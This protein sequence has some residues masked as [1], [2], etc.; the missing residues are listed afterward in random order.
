VAVLSVASMMAVVV[1]AFAGHRI[2]VVA[3]VQSEKMQYS[4]C[5]ASCHG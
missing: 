2:L 1:V 4:Q 5:Q 3:P